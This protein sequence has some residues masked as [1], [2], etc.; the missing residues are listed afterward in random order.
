MSWFP[1]GS[2][3]SKV[4]SPQS[5]APEV[6][7]IEVKDDDDFVLVNNDRAKQNNGYSDPPPMYPLIPGLSAGSSRPNGI[8]QGTAALQPVHQL[9]GVPF[10]LSKD[11][12]LLAMSQESHHYVVLKAQAAINSVDESA[13]KYDFAVEKSVLKETQNF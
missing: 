9:H 12:S 11:T 6:A 13:F 7:A 10:R 2:K 8:Q 4:S 5:L 1:F 3:K